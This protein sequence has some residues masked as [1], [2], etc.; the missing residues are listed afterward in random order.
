[1]PKVPP[2]KRK[3]FIRKLKIFGFDGPFAGG[4]HQFLRSEDGMKIIIPNPHE[5]E[6]SGILQKVILK[7]AKISMEDFLET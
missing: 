1:M 6:I 4:K 7:Q 5:K 3:N 2:I